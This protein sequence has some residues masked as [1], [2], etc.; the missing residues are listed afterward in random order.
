MGYSSGQRIPFRFTCMFLPKS[1]RPASLTLLAILL[2]FTLQIGCAGRLKKAAVGSF[3]DDVAAATAKLDDVTLVSQAGATFLVLMEGLLESNPNDRDLLTSAAE[4][5][6]SYGALVEL[7][8]KH[9]AAA[10]YRRGMIHGRRALTQRA[11]VSELIEAPYDR[12]VAVADHLRPRDVPMVFW[13]TASWGAWISV[14]TE[15]VAAI[16]DLPKVIF[17]MEWILANNETFHYGS[18][19]VFLGMYHSALP[20]SLGGNPD[21][22]KMHFE[23]ALEISSDRA[24]MVH[25]QMARSYARQIFDRELYESLLQTVIERPAGTIP[26]LTLQNATAKLLAKRLLKEA[27]AF[28]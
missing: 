3:V 14:S 13:A 15:S 8:N 2:L 19:H 4:L 16:A 21:K 26:E 1:I 18:P 12:F 10:L 25:V 24:L 23:R 9:R 17:L 20:K 22:A 27:D 5:Y 6:T 11:E 28:F 7:E